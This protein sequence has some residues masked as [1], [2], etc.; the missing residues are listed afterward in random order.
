MVGPDTRLPAGRR[1][2]TGT[3][4]LLSHAGLHTRLLQAGANLLFYPPNSDV[5]IGAVF[6]TLFGAVLDPED[7]V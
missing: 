4:R 7:A 3:R 2:K 5:D 6:E 1:V